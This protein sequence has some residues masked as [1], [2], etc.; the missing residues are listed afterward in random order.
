MGLFDDTWGSYRG[1]RGRALFCLLLHETPVLK[2]RA[3]V[4]LLLLLCAAA[5]T[6]ARFARVP[7]SDFADLRLLKVQSMLIL[8]FQQFKL[9]DYKQHATLM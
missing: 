9:T 6:G 4:L 5:H 3:E 8:L 7:A 1:S 2:H